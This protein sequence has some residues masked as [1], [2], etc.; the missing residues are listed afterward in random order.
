VVLYS[1]WG[2]TD[3]EYEIMPVADFRGTQILE[4]ISEALA[5]ARRTGV[6]PESKFVELFYRGIRLFHVAPSVE[7]VA[8]GTITV[9]PH[10]K[11]QDP[12]TEAALHLTSG[13]FVGRV[14]TSIAVRA[15]T[16]ES[17]PV[18]AGI[19][20]QLRQASRTVF[21]A[22]GFQPARASEDSVVAGAGGILAATFQADGGG[23]RHVVFAIFRR[24]SA[25]LQLLAQQYISYVRYP[26]DQSEYGER[27]L[28][29]LHTPSG[30]ALL[31][32]VSGYEYTGNRIYM[33][34]GTRW[35]QVFPRPSR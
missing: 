1:A 8:A 7:E 22:Y 19:M 33:P 35:A 5:E 15:I 34:R 10:L 32:E 25:G 29:F 24:S 14:Y 13:G 2:A 18:P 11:I 23:Q 16:M 17:E 3:G 27:P 6:Q 21:S 12:V 9:T 20:P 26:D 28:A 31:T 30:T 4:P